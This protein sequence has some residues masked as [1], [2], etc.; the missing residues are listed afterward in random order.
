M[1]VPSKAVHLIR[2]FQDPDNSLATVHSLCVKG[3]EK[4]ARREGCSMCC[5]QTFVPTLFMRATSKVLTSSNLKILTLS[6][7][8]PNF[9]KI[10]VGL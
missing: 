3:R 2:R 8:Q 6:S 1:P 4:Q 10:S 9:S 7:Y 5:K